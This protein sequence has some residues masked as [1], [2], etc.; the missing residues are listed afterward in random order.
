MALSD[1]AC[2]QAKPRDKKYRLA[3]GGGLYLL[4]NPKGPKLPNG[5]KLWQLYYRHDGT[6]RTIALGPYPTLTLA[7]A[8]AERE[9]AQ[10]DKLAGRDPAD[11]RKGIV[12]EGLTFR[13]FA[14][15][16]HE[17]WKVGKNAGYV[18]RVWARL[19]DDAF[20]EI[21]DKD[22]LAITPQDVLAMLRKVEDRGAIES[23]K[24][25]KMKVSEVFSFAI[26]EGKASIDPTLS[27]GRALKPKPAAKRR[28]MV[29]TAGLGD[30]SLAID[31]YDSPTHG[32][33]TETRLALQ[34]TLLTAVRTGE[35]RDAAWT[36]IEGDLWRIPAAR[37][38]MRRE[39]L[40]PLSKQAL[41]VLAEVKPLSKN[42]LIFPGEG[43]TRMSE[44]TMLFGLY[45]LGYHR[46]QTVHGFR[47]LFSTVL[48]EAEF[49]RDWIELQLA[50]VEENEVRGAYNAAEYMAGR[51]TMMQAWADH[52]D[53][54]R[55]KALLG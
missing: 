30:L 22:I 52:I 12:P 49:N 24:R 19:E 41:A 17:A 6:Q 26:A 47:S 46:K 36:E 51:R 8:R 40:V 54:E 44:N 16:N 9:K 35:I 55:F 25:L 45:K 43:G 27:I 4:V 10:R 42:G 38:K 23:A 32:G 53:S 48:N 5:S 3:D 15:A 50:H 39:H 28:A 21:G 7:G 33:R 1:T 18:S 29:G 2:R 31:T 14:K 37:M 13:D 11:A 34:F 20:P